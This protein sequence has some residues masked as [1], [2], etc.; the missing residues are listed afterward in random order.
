VVQEALDVMSVVPNFSS[1]IPRRIVSPF[2][3]LS[4]LAGAEITTFLAPQSR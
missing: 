1:L 2:V 3:W 4:P